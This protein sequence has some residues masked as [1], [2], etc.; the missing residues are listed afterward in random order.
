VRRSKSNSGK[1]AFAP[2]PDNR[3]GFREPS[4][5]QGFA[6]RRSLERVF[7]ERNRL[8]IRDVQAAFCDHVR[9]S[10]MTAFA[11]MMIF[12]MIAVMATLC[13]FPALV[14]RLQHGFRSGLK[15]AA[16]SAGM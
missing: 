11:V 1:N 4:Y 13:G 8:S 15:R 5:C 3:Q 10:W 12:R 7:L 16:M 2:N 14:S 9:L 6:E